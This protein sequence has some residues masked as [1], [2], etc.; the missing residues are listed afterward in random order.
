MPGLGYRVIAYVTV[1][2]SNLLI[3]ARAESIRSFASQN[4]DADIGIVSSNVESV[5]HFFDGLRPK[6]VSHFGP[7]NGDLGH[8]LGRFV[9]NV[10]VVTARLPVG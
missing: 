5:Q 10:F 4:Y 1:V 3:T 9:A 6:R 7:G 8:A 2:T